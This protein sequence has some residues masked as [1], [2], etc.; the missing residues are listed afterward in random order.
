MSSTKVFFWDFDGVLMNSNDVR[1]QG[2]IEVLSE[3]PQTEVQQLLAF[4]R[5]NRGLSRYVK[6]R[7]FFEEVRGESISE[8][9][10]NEWASRFSKQIKELLVDA[11]L[12]I[13]DSIMF[14]RKN[15]ESYP[16]HVVSG[17]DGNELRYICEA[18]QIDKYFISIHGSP[19]PKKQ[20]VSTLIS[21]RGYVKKNCILI[22]DSIND[23]E[24]S[25]Y[26]GIAF[27][28]YNNSE[29]RKFDYIDSFVILDIESL[30][31]RLL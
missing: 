30:A 17:S 29:L 8:E 24:A 26:N 2:F 28:G 4:H 14:I 11:S 1:D 15:H 25:E 23:Y 19:T 16:M 6:F 27:F 13:E 31:I 18:L 5:K 21:E 12:L 22:G 20:L 9:Q 3:F 7:Y 10:V